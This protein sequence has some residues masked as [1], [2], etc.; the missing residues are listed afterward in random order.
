MTYFLLFIG[1]T[2]LVGTILFGVK[3]NKKIKFNTILSLFFFGVMLSIPFILI[4]HLAFGI[5]ILLIILIFIA[6]EALLSLLE[7]K[8]KFLHDLIHHNI[9]E[10][11]MISFLLIG[12]GFTYGEISATILGGSSS[13]TE[14]ISTIPFKITYA[15]LMH[16]VFAYATSL[17][18]IGEVL[19]EGFIGSLMRAATY[20][21]RIG[22]ISISHFLYA[23]SIE[24]NL[25]LLI[26]I[27]LTAG[28]SAFF[29]FKKHLDSKPQQIEQ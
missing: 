28:T 7:Y 8:V 26:G 14:L 20:Y 19:A 2:L 4:E 15:L 22:I 29:Y 16:T 24:H 25:I 11:R 5:S 27:L 12:F 21:I 18:Q 13:M 9:K 10:L 3:M 1:L 23:F 6:I 17:I